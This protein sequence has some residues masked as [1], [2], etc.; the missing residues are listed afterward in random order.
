MEHSRHQ[1]GAPVESGR[2]FCRECRAPQIRFA[3]PD[4]APAP[5]LVGA[6]LPPRVPLSDGNG[7]GALQW[8]QAWQAAFLGGLLSAVM[9]VFPF[10]LLGLGIVAGGALSVVVYRRHVPGPP[11]RVGS[12][13]WLGAVSGFLGFLVFAVFFT[14]AVLLFHA[15]PTIRGLLIQAINQSIAKTA[16]DPQVRQAAEQ[17]KTPEGLAVMLVLSMLIMLAFFAFFSALGG[18]LGAN[19]VRKNTNPEDRA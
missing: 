5:D 8:P 14:L 16:A 10:G 15:W 11:L 18:A 4:A 19:I 17:L 7:P 9:M 13:A 3:S 2:P 1:C 12:G 6:V